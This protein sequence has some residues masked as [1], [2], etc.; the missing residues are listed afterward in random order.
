[1][2][3]QSGSPAEMTGRKGG[4]VEIELVD[5]A[6]ELRA[7]GRD[8][9]PA[10]SV[11]TRK[12]VAG[13]DNGKWNSPELVAGIIATLASEHGMVAGDHHSK[14][15]YNIELDESVRESIVRTAD[16]AIL[17]IGD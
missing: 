17:A 13:I 12:V 4:N 8:V 1:M 9:S 11:L 2:F 16:C 14:L 7:E 5:P 3:G 15:Q 10:L 6:A